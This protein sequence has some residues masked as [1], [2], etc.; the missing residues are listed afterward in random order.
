MKEEERMAEHAK[1]SGS[2]CRRNANA[3]MDV[4]SNKA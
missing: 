4:Q 2:L 3:T 1:E